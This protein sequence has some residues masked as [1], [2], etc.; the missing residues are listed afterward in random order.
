MSIVTLFIAM[1]M[2]VSSIYGWFGTDL[3]LVKVEFTAAYVDMKV[4]LY[5]GNDFDRDGILDTLDDGTDS[6]SVI[7]ADVN[8][9]EIIEPY[10]IIISNL[11]PTQVV[12]YMLEVSNLGDVNSKMALLWSSEDK[13]NTLLSVTAY[14]IDNNG[15]KQYS[16]KVFL[17]DTPNANNVIIEDVPLLLED[18]QEIYLQIKL[19][20]LE[21]L[22]SNGINITESDYQ[23]L[24]GGVCVVEQL[25]LQITA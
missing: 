9:D 16:D 19:E 2:L 17:Y 3:P 7:F 11:L 20:T 18:K 10:G 23:R 24:L 21:S 13:L 25:T 15:A 8:A 14:Y 5:L 22:Q 1:F 4:G 6:Y 12:S